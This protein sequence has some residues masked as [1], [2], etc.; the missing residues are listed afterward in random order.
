MKQKQH[1]IQSYFKYRFSAKSRL[2]HGVH[3][4]FVFQL[5]QNVFNN[6]GQYY[7]YNAIE[8]QRTALSQNK[9]IINIKDMGA[10]SSVH[11]SNRRAVRSIAKTSLLNPEYA[12]LLFR[13]VNYFQ[14][15]SILELGTSLGLTTAY[16]AS[17]KK[18]AE[19]YTIE[20][21][22]SIKNIAE[23]H[24]AILGLKNIHSVLGSFDEQLPDV[25][26]KMDTVD[27][28][29]IDGNHAYEPTLRYFEQILPKTTPG[30]VLIFDDIYWSESMTKAWEE[31]KSHPKVTVSIDL[32]RMGLIFFRTES[33]KE[34]FTIRFP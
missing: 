13:L 31:I 12:Q 24:F 23:Q 8:Q 14:P 22:P 21:C 4:P 25:L 11:K 3:S 16:L 9:T 34:D 19:V 1:Q 5:I 28:A 18:Q 32:Y 27:F 33:S 30:S 29:F 20:A 6:K 7:A 2:G 17:A 26:K 10:G 15:K